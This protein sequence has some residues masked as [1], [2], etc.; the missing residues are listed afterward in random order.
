MHIR[1]H[2]RRHRRRPRCY[3]IPACLP[4]QARHDSRCQ[5]LFR[6]HQRQ[7][8][9]STATGSTMSYST[10]A[11]RSMKPLR[12]TQALLDRHQAVALIRFAGTANV[13]E[14]LKQGI[15]ERTHRW[16]PHYLGGEGAAQN[17]EPQHLPHPAGFADGAEHMVDHLV[18][19]GVR[20][21]PS[22]PERRLRETGTGRG[23]GARES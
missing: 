18:T 22:S 9:V 8:A 3:P 2:C 5:D 13:G 15:L 23:G 11:T 4:V 14:V 1:S 21:L 20:R 17:G 12:L 7:A 16:S 10:T 6:T 19:V